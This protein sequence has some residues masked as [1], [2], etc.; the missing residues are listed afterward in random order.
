VVVERVRSPIAAR[1][2]LDTVVAMSNGLFVV[3]EGTDGAGKTV[4][5]DRIAERLRATGTDVV[6]TR[7]PGASPLG[8]VV[9]ELLLHGT[10]EFGARAETLLFAADRAEHI[11]LVIEPA[12]DRGDVVLCDRFVD[13][14]LA[15]QGAGRGLGQ[16]EL[17]SVCAFATGGRQPDLVVV[18]DLSS[19]AAQG[20]Q[21][22]RAVADRIEKAQMGEQVRSLLLSR[23][24]ADP[25]RYAVVDADADLDTVTERIWSVLL[26]RL[27]QS[28]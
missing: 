8:L 5:L 27:E 24:A 10:V 20:R 23:A 16:D 7:E 17:L 22:G 14:T 21:Q 4:Q 2:R 19:E 15:Y 12:L 3:F 6:T 18:L 13:S 25:A 9:R 11:R 28:A 1:N 26:P